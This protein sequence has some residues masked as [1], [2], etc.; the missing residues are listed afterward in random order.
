MSS[1]R[2]QL[3]NLKVAYGQ[4]TII[5]G[6]NLDVPENELVCLMGRN[7]VGKTTTLK[8]VVGLLSPEAGSIIMNGLPLDALTTSARARA[9]IAY[10]P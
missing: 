8:A 3:K 6:I 9:G 7:G 10:V 5:R 2:L 4:S 1:P